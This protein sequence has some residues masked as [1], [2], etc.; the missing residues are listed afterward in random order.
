MPLSTTRVSAQ[1]Q[2][3]ASAADGAA[4]SA[5]QVWLRNYAS[6]V[7]RALS[8]AEHYKVVCPA[9]YFEHHIGVVSAISLRQQQR[10]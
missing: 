2:T 9:R 10:P 3:A 1:K 8:R 4:G 5:Q 6:L 7:F